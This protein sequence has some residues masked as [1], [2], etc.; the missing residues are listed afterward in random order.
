M[1]SLANISQKAV[2]AIGS[3]YTYTVTKG[4]HFNSKK[5]LIGLNKA[6]ATSND[7]SKETDKWLKKNQKNY[8]YTYTKEKTK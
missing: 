3:K 5:F 2:S 1:R 6:K 7:Y 4:T 8:G